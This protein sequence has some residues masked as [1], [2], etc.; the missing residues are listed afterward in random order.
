[1]NRLILCLKRNDQYNPLQKNGGLKH[2]MPCFWHDEA[3]T[4]E[5]ILNPKKLQSEA[6]THMEVDRALLPWLKAIMEPIEGVIPGQIIRDRQLFFLEDELS[7]ALKN[8]DLKSKWRSPDTMGM[9]DA[10]TVDFQKITKAA[11]EQEWTEGNK[12]RDVKAMTSGTYL[13]GP[14]VGDDYAN[15][16][17]AAA[18]AGTMVGNLT[19][20]ANGNFT[21]TA[22]ANFSNA[23]GGFVLTFGSNIAHGGDVTAAP[24]MTV[25]HNSH[26]IAWNVTGGGN[27]IESGFRKT[28]STNGSNSTRGLL[29][30]TNSGCLIAARDMWYDG[31]SLTGAGVLH[32]L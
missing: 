30:G 24:V 18:D 6:F 19:F 17:A 15:A 13:V 27:H 26:G 10:K 5:F 14:D 25:N 16:A 4:G 9:L 29:I 22:L 32:N 23:S 8:A 20:N 3:T 28:R 7:T 21:D 12:Y 2:L 1:M 31:G 11:L